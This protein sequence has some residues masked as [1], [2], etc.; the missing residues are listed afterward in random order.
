MGNLVSENFGIIKEYKTS[1]LKEYCEGF[2]EISKI[3][4]VRTFFA[5]QKNEIKTG[6]DWILNM[7]KFE[8]AVEE[9]PEFRDIAYFH[10]IIH[11]PKK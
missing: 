6:K 4:G 9:V 7:Y 1:E 11:K 10:H 2:L 3:Y 8:C 5:L